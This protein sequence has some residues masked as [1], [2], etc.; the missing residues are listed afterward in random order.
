[1]SVQE[2]GATPAIA[3]VRADE[4][5]SSLDTVRG[6]ALLGIL[7]LNITAFGLPMAAYVN[8]APAGGSSGLNLVAWT[9][10]SIFGDGK[11]RAIFSLSF[12]AG[13]YLL[14]ERLSRQ[15]AGAAAADIHYRRMLWLLL[16]GMIH[17]Y[18]IWWGD[19]L[20]DYAMLG[21]LLYPLRRLSAR[22]LLI[23]AGIMVLV[24]TAA[25]IG[26]HYH[27]RDLQ[28]EYV[29][30][31]A[32]ERAGGKLTDEQQDTK[33]EWENVVRRYAPTAKDLKAETDAHLGGYLKL[34]KF[35][36]REVFRSHGS[37][38]YLP[39]P[40]FDMLSMMLIGIAMMKTGVLEGGRSTRFYAWMA[41]ISFAIGMPLNCWS[42]WWSIKGGFSIDSQMIAG[43]AY[44]A[45]RVTAFGY[46]ALII[47]AV[48]S[49]ALRAITRTL[50]CV[51][52][53]A[54]TNYI[55][56][57]LI[58][59][60]IFEG[61]GL[62]LFGKLQRFELYAVVL[63]VWLVIL[64]LSPVWLGHFRFGPLEW[65]WRSLTYWKRQPLRIG[66]QAARATS[67]A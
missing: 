51:G 19:I 10:M 25:P 27:L 65:L 32:A 1:M 63:F 53:M 52:Q 2:P 46:V 39:F 31:E 7:L 37:P 54:F 17:A 66:A 36:A 44:E 5:I 55:L 67:P 18:L 34:L 40:W 4:R 9:V 59:T 57:S 49:G 12:G 42:A 22:A 14:V 21:L 8:P 61:Y 30:V 64:V 38:L 62:G 13:V 33:K 29:K 11:M 45:G 20:F 58:C 6:F 24:L 16:F 28:G 48:K 56:T 47:L 50:A 15:G 35:R 41:L 3:P 60:T 23:T 26:Y 43:A